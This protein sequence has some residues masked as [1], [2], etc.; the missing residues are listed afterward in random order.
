[1]IGF[2]DPGWFAWWRG[3]LTT[4]RP[5]VHELAT[6]CGLWFLDKLKTGG[7]ADAMVRHSSVVNSILVQR[8]TT[9]P[10]RKE[11]QS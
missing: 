6:T 4:I 1:V 9:K 7:A 5:P 2:G 10:L 8:A 11:K 3:G